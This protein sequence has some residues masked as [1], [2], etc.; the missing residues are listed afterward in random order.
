MADRDAERNEIV[1]N[2]VLD[3]LSDDY[4]NLDQILR[5]L[6]RLP[7]VADLTISSEEVKIAL[8]RLVESGYA[9][10]YL[11]RAL[12]PS[13]EEINAPLSPGEI[14]RY[15]FLQTN[16]GRSLNATLPLLYDPR[17]LDT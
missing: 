11:L 17:E 13:A 16:E 14:E 8:L 7:I 3:E 5:S 12:P 9:K 4:E 15:Y 10:A 2:L 1:D 6:S